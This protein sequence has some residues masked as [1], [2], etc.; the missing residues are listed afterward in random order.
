[1]HT[2]VLYALQSDAHKSCPGSSLLTFCPAILYLADLQCKTKAGADGIEYFQK[3]HGKNDV[4]EFGKT[5]PRQVKNRTDGSRILKKIEMPLSASCASFG[6]L[7][8]NT[9]ESDFRFAGPREFG[10]TRKTVIWTSDIV[11]WCHVRTGQH[12]FPPRAHTPRCSYV[13][14]EYTKGLEIA[15]QESYVQVHPAYVCQRRAREC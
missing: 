4:S 13:Y 6:N 15:A 14:P 10:C 1:M 7:S 5:G 2:A 3:S 12:V 9:P 11:L 8:S